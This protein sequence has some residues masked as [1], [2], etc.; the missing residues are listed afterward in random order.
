MVL[1]LAS[2]SSFGGKLAAFDYLFLAALVLLL[3]VAFQL[4]LRCRRFSASGCVSAAA[5]FRLLDVFALPVAR[6]SLYAPRFGQGI[7]FLA[8]DCGRVSLR[9][10]GVEQLGS[11]LGS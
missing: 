4:C 7:C 5:D 9:R 3:A 2:G 1:G 10:R 6:I 8:P 11:S